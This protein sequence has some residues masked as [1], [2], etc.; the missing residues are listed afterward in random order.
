VEGRLQ[1]IEPRDEGLIAQQA[2]EEA[3]P[4]S[5]DKLVHCLFLEMAVQMREPVDRHQFMIGHPAGVGVVGEAL[6]AG[7]PPRIVEFADKHIA[8]NKLNVHRTTIQLLRLAC[9]RFQPLIHIYAN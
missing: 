3:L 2:R 6:K 4:V 5:P 7:A 1:A 8:S 9:L